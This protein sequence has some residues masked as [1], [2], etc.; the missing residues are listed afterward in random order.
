MRKPRRDLIC[1]L[2][3]RAGGGAHG[4]PDPGGAGGGSS[5]VAGR[6][7]QGQPR[8]QHGPDGRGAGTGH[9]K[10]LPAGRAARVHLPR[11]TVWKPGA[12]QGLRSGARG[13]TLLEVADDLDRG[14]V[15]KQPFLQLRQYME[16]T[17][18]PQWPYPRVRGY[19]RAATE[20]NLTGAGAKLIRRA[21]DECMDDTGQ[22]RHIIACDGSADPRRGTAGWAVALMKNNCQQISQ[23]W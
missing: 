22:R 10:A 3:G 21:V 4:S 8:A 7:Q 14:A 13:S 18:R 15:G 1:R 16:A 9:G 12:R 6:S 5:A 17:A 20:Y 11:G 2:D 23:L 19:P